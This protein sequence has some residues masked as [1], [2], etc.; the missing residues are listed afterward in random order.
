MFIFAKFKQSGTD[1]SNQRNEAPQGETNR[2]VEKVRIV[3]V[4]KYCVH[5]YSQQERT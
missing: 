4:E 3:H 1:G 2:E 5:Y